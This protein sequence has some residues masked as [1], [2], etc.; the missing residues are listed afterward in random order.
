MATEQPFSRLLLKVGVLISKDI[1][2]WYGLV[3]LSQIHLVLE[4][5]VVNGQRSCQLDI[6]DAS[7][8]YFRHH[9]N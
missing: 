3:D 7:K 6:L 1:V 2:V 5:F 9:T 8:I 4:K